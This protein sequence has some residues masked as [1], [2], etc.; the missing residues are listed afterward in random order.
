MAR[1]QHAKFDE[2]LALIQLGRTIGKMD[3][4]SLEGGEKYLLEGINIYKEMNVRPYYSQGYLLLGDMYTDAGRVDEARKYL[5]K[6]KSN[7]KDLGL[8]FWLSR[9]HAV[10]ARLQEV[11]K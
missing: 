11:S 7:F 3:P 1:Q 9:T 6:A 8:D 10:L 4:A 5:E 2:G